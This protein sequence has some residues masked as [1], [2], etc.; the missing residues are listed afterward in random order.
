FF[1][2][3]G[4]CQVYGY[5]LSGQRHL[6]AGKRAANTL[7]RF[8]YGLVAKPH[9]CYAR[10]AIGELAFEVYYYAAGANIKD[11][12]YWFWH[13]DNSLTSSRK[14]KA[15]PCLSWRATCFSLAV[16]W[17]LVFGLLWNNGLREAVVAS[18][19]CF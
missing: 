12:L 18:R 10:Q 16:F 8:V 15:P 13:V 9:N 7:A 5:S 2:Y 11:G 17:V 14:S 19:F 3:V 1:W 4:R 6:T